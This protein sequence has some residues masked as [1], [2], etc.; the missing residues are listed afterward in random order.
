[1]WRRKQRREEYRDVQGAIPALPSIYEHLRSHL[2]PDRLTLMK[3]GMKLPDEDYQKARMGGKPDSIGFAPGAVDGILRGAPIRRDEANENALSLHRALLQFARRPTS[4]SEANMVRLMVNSHAATSLT[5]LM[6][7]LS[8]GPP[9]NLPRFYDQ[10]RALFLNSGHREVV[11]FALAMM[12]SFRKEQDLELFRTAACHPEFTQYAID[13]ISRVSHDPVSELIALTRKSE[14]WGKVN[15]IERLMGNDRKEVRDFL[16]GQGLD[17]IPNLEGYVAL[18]LAMRYELHEILD[19]SQVD[20]GLLRGAAQILR[21]L[22]YEAVDGG[23]DGNILD[24]PE[25]GLAVERFLSHFEPVASF[26]GDFLTV[27]AIK[28]FAA[29]TEFD[30]TRMLSAGW[31]D[32]RR[33]RVL[34]TCNRIIARPE[35]PERVKRSLSSPDPEGE[36]RAIT[37][38]K[39][40]GMPLHDYFVDSLR[41][42]PLRPFIWFH[43]VSGA[44]ET[45]MDE[46]LLLARELLDYGSI[47]TGPAEESDVGPGRERYTC[48]NYILQELRRFPGKGWEV[49][50]ISLR[51]PTTTNRRYALMALRWWRSPDATTEVISAVRNAL[52]DP[53]EQV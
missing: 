10:M 44:D 29:S 34:E 36:W 3:T 15:L 41:N 33:N 22:A 23:P 13:A 45:R 28:Q 51:S 37:V 21:T 40:L 52:S 8:K 12:A 31:D 47:A 9:E 6:H 53:S 11:K 18:P 30:E 4:G 14:G 25:G 19:A 32:R 46:A 16:V 5:P 1:M 42:K 27:W 39:Q 43:F 2:A 7:A 35:W 26:A 38:A 17:D 50:R 48:L 49:I 20:P 24:Y